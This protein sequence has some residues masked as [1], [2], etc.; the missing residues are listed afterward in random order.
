M[1]STLWF[2]AG[3]PLWPSPHLN[4]SS[5]SQQQE[6]SSSPLDDYLTDRLRY[7]LTLGESL[8]RVVDDLLK[9]F[10]VWIGRQ[11]DRNHGVRVGPLTWNSLLLLLF[12]LTT[13]GL[14]I[15]PRQ[16]DINTY[17]PTV[18]ELIQVGRV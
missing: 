3:R 2:S 10:K 4:P 18:C 16:V 5:S 11:T 7:I 8:L 1:I 15:T 6:T 14:E 17:F 9:L 13:A 12:Q